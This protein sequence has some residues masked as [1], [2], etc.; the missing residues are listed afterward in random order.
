MGRYSRLLDKLLLFLTIVVVVVGTYK[1]LVIALDGGAGGDYST[2]IRAVD[3][4]LLG[5][6]PYAWTVASYATLDADPGNKGYAY[7]PGIMYMNSVLKIASLFFSYSLGI[8]LALPF[9]MK[10]PGILATLSVVGFFVVIFYKKDHWALLFSTVLWLFNPYFYIKES[11]LGYDAVTIALMV[12]SLFYL[13]KDEVT[14]G[15]LYALSVIFKT[16]PVILGFIFLLRTKDRIRFILAAAYIFL[17]VS[18]PFYTD[19]ETFLKGSVFVH[20]NRFVQGRPYLYYI[21]YFYHVEL[22]RIISFEFYSIASIV[23]GWLVAIVLEKL[24]WIKD[25]FAL[26]VFP[27]LTFYLFTPVLNRTYPIWGMPIFLVGTYRLFTGK[28]RFLFYV[29]NFGYWVFVCWYLRQWKDGF[30]IWHP[31]D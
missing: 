9:L 27:F 25:K 24:G 23:S 5:K 7:L 14:S 31:I 22:F 30:H 26:A 16:F 4:L 1:R 8:N 17:L 15:V 13:A 19:L 6:N 10:F 12:W 18:V 3:E 20:G 11:L 28:Y 2:H 29:L 21:S